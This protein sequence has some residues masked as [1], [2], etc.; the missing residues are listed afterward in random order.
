MGAIAIIAGLLLAVIVPLSV[1]SDRINTTT[2]RQSEVQAVA[3]HWAS[4]AGWSVVGGTPKGDQV[5]VD[6]TGPD[7][8][9][10]LA[11]LR[12]DLD[13]AGLADV[14]VQV[15]LTVA[16]YQPVPK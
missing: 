16:G 6:A 3:G 15:H 10:S 1:N 7:P 13:A 14:N 9:P 11:Q 5:L 8:A 4:Q 12:Q 2:V